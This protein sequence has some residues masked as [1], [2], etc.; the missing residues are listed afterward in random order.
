MEYWLDEDG[1]FKI[2]DNFV[3]FGAGK[4]GC[5]GQSVAIKAMYA[6]FGLMMNKYKFIA[7]NDDPEGLSIEQKWGFVLSVATI[8]VNVQKR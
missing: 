6:M 8:G 3:L 1:K 7:K 4:R 2:N 5:V